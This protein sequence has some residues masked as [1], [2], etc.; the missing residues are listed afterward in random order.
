MR[1]AMKDTYNYLIMKNN[2]NQVLINLVINAL[3][4]VLVM[5]GLET[6]PVFEANGM[7][8]DLL[9]TNMFL[10]FFIY[11]FGRLEVINWRKKNGAKG[12]EFNSE[13]HKKVAKLYKLHPLAGFGILW[14][15][16]TLF[17]AIPACLIT[18]VIYGGAGMPILH[19]LFFK[20]VY[21]CFMANYVANLGGMVGSIEVEAN[22][23]TAAA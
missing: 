14:V 21:A 5:G 10:I 6:L 22:G 4:V 16:F 19:F 17:V 1:K 2:R 3:V 23:D 7:L 18:S 9:V 15:K 8:Q 20:L 11:I 12:L 13:E